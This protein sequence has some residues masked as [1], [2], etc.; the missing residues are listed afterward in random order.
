MRGAGTDDGSPDPAGTGAA[1]RAQEAGAG[2]HYPALDGVYR[3]HYRALVRLAA[4]LTTDLVMAEEIAA[5]S[6]AALISSAARG[7]P[8]RMLFRLRQQ[9]VLRSRRLAPGNRDDGTP[10]G[11]HD[12]PV[13]KV[14]GSLP[15]CQREAVV[16]RH[17][18][19]L[20]EREVAAMTGSS[21]R[22]GRRRLAVIHDAACQSLLGDGSE[23]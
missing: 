19:G 1:P 3:A 18:L 2:E 23:A 4:L 15:L 11:R 9:V 5:D 20:G 16:L 6:V 13:M 10:R 17:Y 12:S 21:Q 14:L 8:E 7:T 22:A